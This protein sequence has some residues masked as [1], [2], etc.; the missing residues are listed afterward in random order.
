[1]NKRSLE[2][3]SR[4]LSLVLRHQPEAVGVNLDPSGWIDVDTLLSA[5]AANGHALTRPDLEEIVRTNDKQRFALDTTGNRIRANQ[6]HSLPVELGLAPR[7]PPDVLYH[8]TGERAVASILEHGLE[9]RGR[10][11]VHLSG[12]PATARKVGARHGAPVVFRVDASAMQRDG[13]EFLQSANG[14]WLTD[15]VPAGYLELQES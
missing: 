12:D 9:R 5:L 1:M 10:T 7:T 4:L 13:H 8:G 11:H 3:T 14:V 6:G 15:A 2:R